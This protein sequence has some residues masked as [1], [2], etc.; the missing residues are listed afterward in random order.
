M[1]FRAEI[2]VADLGGYLKERTV[3]VLVFLLPP[4]LAISSVSFHPFLI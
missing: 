3:R 1:Y 4:L 2:I